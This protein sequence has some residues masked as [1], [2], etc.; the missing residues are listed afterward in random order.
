M[1]DGQ[2][3]E[4]TLPMCLEP[5]AT[6]ARLYLTRQNGGEL[7]RAGDF[8]S[9]AP[10]ITF[11]TLPALGRPAQFAHLS[12]VQGPDHA[13]LSKRHGASSVG[14]FRARGILPEALSN[15]L[16]LLGWSLDGETE[17]FTMETMLEHFRLERVSASPATFDRDKLDWMNQHWIN[18]LLSVDDLA[19]RCLPFLIDAGTIRRFPTPA[20]SAACSRPV[21]Y[22]FSSPL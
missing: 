22:G 8:A 4:V 20:S 5:G 15:Y 17:I 11:A 2:A 21:L 3:L 1:V 7:L 12:L 6:G 9:S 10:T 19:T 18:H 14:E 13:P 16:A